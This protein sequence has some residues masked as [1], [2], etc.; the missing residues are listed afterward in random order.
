MPS[1][2]QCLSAETIH[3]IKLRTTTVIE[4]LDKKKHLLITETLNAFNQ[5]SALSP[6]KIASLSLTLRNEILDNPETYSSVKEALLS[7]LE[8]IQATLP[9]VAMVKDLPD[10]VLSLINNFLDY[11]SQLQLRLVSRQWDKVVSSPSSFGDLLQR[12]QFLPRSLFSHSSQDITDII[13]LRQFQDNLQLAQPA[14]VLNDIRTITERYNVRFEPRLSNYLP[15]SDKRRSK[16]MRRLIIAVAIVLELVSLS[17]IPLI[18][19]NSVLKDW[20]IRFIWAVIAASIIVA[21]CSFS[22]FLCYHE[23]ANHRYVLDEQLLTAT[24]TSLEQTIEEIG[25]DTEFDVQTNQM[26]KWLFLLSLRSFERDPEVHGLRAKDFFANF[27]EYVEKVL[28]TL[29][30]SEAG[31]TEKPLAHTEDAVAITIEDT[32]AEQ[33]FRDKLTR[34]DNPHSSTHRFFKQVQERRK[35]QEQAPVPQDETTSLLQDHKPCYQ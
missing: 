8:K 5:D 1:I 4:R 26:I 2:E 17:F 3:Q 14:T 19:V 22:V 34:I 13:T 29:N 12:W 10:D 16:I 32:S 30:S 28:K 6:E 23:S 11:R 21:M 31:S 35:P 24:Q 18:A 9:M 15:F 25:S 27:R 7:Y 33:Y 20:D